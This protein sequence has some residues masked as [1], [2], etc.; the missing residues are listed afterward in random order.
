[1][2]YLG[3]VVLAGL[4]ALGIDI[5]VML[6]GESYARFGLWPLAGGVSLLPGFLP[7]LGL[8]I[9][10]TGML[11]VQRVV[12]AVQAELL[13]LELRVLAA[14]N[15]KAV[16]A[17]EAA[18]LAA[19]PGA[20]NELTPASDPGWSPPAEPDAVMAPQPLDRWLVGFGAVCGTACLLIVLAVMN[21]QAGAIPGAALLL[22]G[23]IAFM[24][25]LFAFER[26]KKGEAITFDSYWGGL[27]GSL[28]GWRLSPATT[29]IALAL[30]FLGATVTIAIGG[31]RGTGEAGAVTINVTAAPDEAGAKG[32]P[33]NVSAPG[34][35]AAPD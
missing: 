28:G 12:P 23:V 20:A 22:C 27:G 34:N 32:A 19:D 15:A 25:A 9:G 26:L 18:R 21:H 31:G 5:W 11:L 35:A 1:M 29:T 10:V 4:F 7:L 8:I 3:I 17:A 2:R 14:R 13:A 16:A 33:A 6:W 24:A 30:I